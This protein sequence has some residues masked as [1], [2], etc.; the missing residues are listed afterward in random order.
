VHLP[1]LH[2]KLLTFYGAVLRLAHLAA[3]ELRSFRPHLPPLD[4]ARLLHPLDAHLPM[5]LARHGE[6]LHALHASAAVTLER[7]GLE[8]RTSAAPTR[9]DGLEARST[10]TPAALNRRGSATAATAMTV[11]AAMRDGLR[12]PAATV[13]AARL[14]RQRG[15]NRHR[16][17]TRSKE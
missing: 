6:A 8:A 10:A 2:A 16:G 1:A 14:C 17:D 7:L 9:P 13:A 3:A 15:R 4:C 11:A 5:F 12:L